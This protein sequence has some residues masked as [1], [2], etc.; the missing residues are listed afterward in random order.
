MQQ[1]FYRILTKKYFLQSDF[2]ASTFCVVERFVSSSSPIHKLDMM[3][4][5]LYFIIVY[6]TTINAY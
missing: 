2:L 5:F 4:V 3:L 1:S 6:F